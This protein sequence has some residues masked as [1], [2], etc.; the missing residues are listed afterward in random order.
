MEYGLGLGMKVITTIAHRAIL[1]QGPHLRDGI[2]Q[3]L[4]TW[5]TYG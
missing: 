5:H 2:C 4:E 3:Q 1:N